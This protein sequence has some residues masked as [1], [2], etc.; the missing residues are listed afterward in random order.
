MKVFITIQDHSEFCRNIFSL[1]KCV[2]SAYILFSLLNIMV[3]CIKLKNK[4]I[5]LLVIVNFFTIIQ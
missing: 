4:C 5:Y 1:Y 3:Y 2:Y